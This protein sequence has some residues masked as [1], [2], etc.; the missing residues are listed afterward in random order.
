MNDVK[1]MR[2]NQ[3]I[4]EFEVCDFELRKDITL[5]TTLS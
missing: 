4:I 3:A 5:T 2:R 1:K